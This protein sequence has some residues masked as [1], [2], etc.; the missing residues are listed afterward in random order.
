MQDAC[1]SKF[2]TLSKKQNS[3]DIESFPVPQ[4]RARHSVNAA[5]GKQEVISAPEV[6]Q[7]F[8]I[9]ANRLGNHRPGHS[10]ICELCKKL[11]CGHCVREVSAGAE[12]LQRNGQRTAVC[13]RASDRG[14]QEFSTFICGQDCGMVSKRVNLTASPEE[15]KALENA[16][17]RWGDQERFCTVEKMRSVCM[18]LLFL[19]TLTQA[20]DHQKS[21]LCSRA[22]GI[23]RWKSQK[24]LLK[25]I[26][27]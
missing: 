6:P 19:Y 21:Q 3:Q 13:Q 11:C 1:I 5:A 8:G 12:V 22:T 9:N 16:G 26:T 20:L 25:N 15:Q 14:L 4:Q 23:R 2:L 17:V 24:T 7:L 18:F 10:S 27:Q